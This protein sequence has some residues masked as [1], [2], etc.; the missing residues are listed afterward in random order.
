[1]KS[2]TK[3][4]IGVMII[5]S[6]LIGFFIGITVDYPKT[7]NAELAGTIGKMDNYRNV[8]ISEKDI[9]LRNDLLSNESFLKGYIQY[10]SVQY[11]ACVK[12][13]DDIDF[14]IK[15]AESIQPFKEKY[16]KEIDDIKLYSETLKQSREDILLALTSL[17][18][19]AQSDQN[20][21]AQLLNLANVAIA[22]NKYSENCI[23]LF[24]ESVEKFIQTNNPQQ[25]TDLLKAHDLFAVNQL[26]MAA[27]T[28][29]KPMLKAYDKKQLLSSN[30]ELNTVHSTQLNAILL[31]D[32]NALKANFPNNEKLQEF[33]SD[34]TKMGNIEKQLGVII[35]AFEKL[36]GI[37]VESTDKL[38][39]VNAN[40]KLGAVIFNADK[41][42]EICNSEKLG[43]ENTEILR[44]TDLERLRCG[45]AQKL[46]INRM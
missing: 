44:V 17:Q 28:N 10:Y 43:I 23:Y 20:N 34:P 27:I 31:S 41:L 26:I 35:P 36:G 40:E 6:L 4:L 33:C 39:A 15:A 21:I 45:D 5:I 32:F 8:K 42:G 13:C 7:D 16:T 37:V 9:Q 24:V 30:L 38:R 3:I 22:Q 19:L 18:N 12:Q 25:Y 29:D 11:T 14:A 2:S 46:G 1:M